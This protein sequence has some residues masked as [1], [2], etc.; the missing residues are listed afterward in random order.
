MKEREFYLPSSDPNYKIRCM[1]W[2]PDGEVKGVLQITHGMTEHIGRYKEFGVWLAEHGIAV[3]GH[4]HLGHGK[5]VVNKDDFGYFGTHG[6][7]ECVI[8]DIRRVTVYAKKLYP[9]KKLFILGHSMG[10]FFTRKYLS[11]YQDGPDGFIIMGTGSPADGLLRVGALLAGAM[12]KVKGEHFRSKLLY[13]MS[14]G[15]YNKK[16]EPV[17]TPQDWLTRDVELAKAYGSDELCQYIFTAA[18]YRDFF[19]VML[20]DSK[21]EKAGNIR[22]NAPMLLISGENDPVGDDGKG[23]RIVFDRY[24]KAGVSDMTLKLYEGARHEVLHELNWEEV[25]EDILQW[26]EIRM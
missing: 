21:A 18:A 12:A 14:L 16:F 9:D 20:Q 6:G 11:V 10:S 17:T 19:H 7:T 2:I 5:T 1:E 3:I 25:F 24:K 22:T 4:D 15:G 8:K 23:V 13:E 26:M